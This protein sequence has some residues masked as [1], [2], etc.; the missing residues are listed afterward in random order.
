MVAWRELW[1][2]PIKAPCMV[3]RAIQLTTH[4][5]QA[6]M[7]GAFIIQTLLQ[8]WAGLT[9]NSPIREVVTVSPRSSQEE[10]GLEKSLNPNQGLNSGL[11][12]S[13]AHL[14]SLPVPHLESWSDTLSPV[15][16][17]E[18]ENVESFTC[19]TSKSNLA[20]EWVGGKM[21]LTNNRIY[22]KFWFV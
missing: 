9:L 18:S 1:D 16:Q 13:M 7:V 22:M 10:V 21:T 20:F 3:P 15:S 5:A 19:I 12:D 17:W 8:L 6:T 11:S 2:P 14:C 4:A